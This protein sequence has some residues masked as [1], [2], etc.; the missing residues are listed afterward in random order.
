M[1]PRNAREA[2]SIPKPTFYRLKGIVDP[3][4]NGLNK[5]FET[6]VCYCDVGLREEITIPFQNTYGRNKKQV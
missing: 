3:P 2:G 5:C 6:A 4:S 1:I